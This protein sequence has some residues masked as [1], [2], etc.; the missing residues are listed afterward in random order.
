MFRFTAKQLS[1]VAPTDA[2]LPPERSWEQRR[3]LLGEKSTSS[4]FPAALTYERDAGC[5]VAWRASFVLLIQLKLSGIALATFFFIPAASTTARARSCALSSSICLV[6]AWFYRMIYKVRAQQSVG[7]PAGLANLRPRR[8]AE[9]AA[10]DGT[11]DATVHERT[12]VQ[13]DTVDALRA[14][15]W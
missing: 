3:L 6:A 10:A 1:N 14:T 11:D 15:D 8:Q 7:G 4:T 2:E 13:E 5:P 12:L 9:R